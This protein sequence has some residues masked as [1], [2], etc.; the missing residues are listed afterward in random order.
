M[1]VLSPLA[2][3]AH[4]GMEGL[5]GIGGGRPVEADGQALE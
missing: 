3:R 2:V 1:A 5:S 4:G